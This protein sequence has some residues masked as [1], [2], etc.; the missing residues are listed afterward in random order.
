MGKEIEAPSTSTASNDAHLACDTTRELPA[1]DTNE[2]V[3]NEYDQRE[4][5]RQTYLKSSLRGTRVVI[6][7]RLTMSRKQENGAKRRYGIRSTRRFLP[8]AF[9]N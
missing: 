6:V 2:Q 3:M 7:A 9:E 4:R 5:R 8:E 1:I